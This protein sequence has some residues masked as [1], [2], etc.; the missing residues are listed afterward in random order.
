MKG[1]YRM[2]LALMT[3]VERRAVIALAGI[4]CLRLLGLFMIL[5]VFAVYAEQLSD[6]TPLRIG[7]ALGIYGLTQAL[8]QIPFG[9]VSD[10]AGR[11]PVI[12]AGLFIFMIGSLVAALS[13]SIFGVIIGRSLQGA[14]AIGC[15]MMALVSD[16][17]QAQHR[18]WAMA[19]LGITIGISFALSMILGPIFSQLMGVRG[20][21]GLTAIFALLAIGALLLWVPT[22]PSSAA[23]SDSIPVLGDIPKVF[24]IPST[25][26]YYFG[27][28][29]LHASL[30]A[31]FLKIPGIIQAAG[32]KGGESWQ[33]YLPILTGS[34]VACLPCLWLM[35]KKKNTSWPL[36][37]V[38]LMLGLSEGSL[39]LAG[40]VFSVGLSLWAF[41]TLFNILEAS[42]PSLVSKLSP[43]H[44][45]GT[46]LG[47]YSSAQFLGLFIGGIA[48]GWC[49]ASYGMVGILG[50]CVALAFTWFFWILKRGLTWQ[51]A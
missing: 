28:F 12:I 39:L 4:F 13:D 15:V 1:F 37:V 51:E 6:V 32:F 33:F 49:D 34:L 36:A 8:L 35:E 27:V 23:G 2:S 40:S 29:V 44:C 30:V 25:R 24:A 17:T 38:V 7:I 31:L 11:K 14:S 18:V 43:P 3:A 50:F 47:I 26:V 5:P 45:R 20:I 19:L 16:L 21:F 9:F 41:F 42:L 22:P 10:R 46:A 48:G